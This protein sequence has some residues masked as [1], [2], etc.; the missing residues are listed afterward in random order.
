MARKRE[1]AG[2]YTALLAGATDITLPVE[3]PWARNV[4][5]MYGVVLGESFGSSRDDVMR[6]LADEGIETRAFFY[7]MHQQP[8]FQ[9]SP[10]PR[11]PDTSG[12]YPVSEHLG[13]SG[14]Y[15]PSGL[16]LTYE[17][18]QCIASALQSCR[19]ATRA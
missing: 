13:R 6:A 5:W 1:I 11:F 12:A 7:P 2:W 15:L 14:L 19:I 10:D 16:T 8:L 4:F 17:Q 9:R 18:A 3:E